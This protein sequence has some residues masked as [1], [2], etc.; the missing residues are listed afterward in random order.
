MDGKVLLLLFAGL[1]GAA[2]YLGRDDAVI[3][4]AQSGPS[5]P[6]LELASVVDMRHAGIRRGLVRDGY[7]PADPDV[8]VFERE[9]RE[10]VGGMV[11]ATEHGHMAFL[12]AIFPWY[13]YP[14]LQ[15]EPG[16]LKDLALLDGC[17]PTAPRH[18]ARVANVFAGPTLQRVPVY[19]IGA[20][21]LDRLALRR[22]E[23]VKKNG[24]GEGPSFTDM[25]AATGL[26]GGTNLMKPLATDV[27][28]LSAPYRFS[29]MEIVVTETAQPVHLVL[30]SAGGRILWNLSMAPGVEI[31]G[32]TLLG[33]AMSAL[34]N[35]PDGVPVEVMDADA[36]ARCD[37][38][39]A[40][41]LTRSDP[42]FVAVEAGD[43][44][45]AEARATL[46]AHA[47]SVEAW[48][49][50]FAGVFGVRDDATRIGQDVAAIAALVGPV[51]ATPEER[52]GYHGFRGRLAWITP[53]AETILDSEE[54]ADARLRRLVDRRAEEIAGRSLADLA[55]QGS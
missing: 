48:N 6:P 44:S 32:V 35:L 14:S 10:I 22:I 39:P 13:S 1:C 49:A 12:D 52:V 24:L 2:W 55:A 20:E 27:G 36:L 21:D 3:G 34:A 54:S 26:S 53:A 11:A 7:D 8:Y 38:V 18:G 31:A 29:A 43:T 23:R 30:Q 9:G 47:E 51:P 16:R 42:L 40:R 45:V 37:I 5:K 25:L 19:A 28:A 4:I 33:G 50:W 41:R 17:R 15:D 46:A